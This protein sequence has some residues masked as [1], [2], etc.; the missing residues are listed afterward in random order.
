M[1]V[2]AAFLEDLEIT[3]GRDD[4]R[5]RASAAFLFVR[6]AKALDRPGDPRVLLPHRDHRAVDRAVR[7][8]RA[9][10]RPSCSRRRAALVRHHAPAGRTSSASDPAAPAACWSSGSSPASVATVIG[11]LVGVTAGYL[12]GVGDES[13]VRAVQ[14]VPGDP[15]AAADHHHRRP[16]AVG[17]RAHRRP[18]HRPHRVGVG[19]PRAAGADAVAAATRLRRGGAGQRREHLAD[20]LRG[21]PAEPHRDHRL[22][23]RR[24]GHLRG[25]VPDHAGVHR[26]HAHHR[27]ELGHDPVLGAEPAGPA[28]RRV[29]VVRPGRAAASPC[30]ARR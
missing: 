3:P 21:D 18:G 23:L 8:E 10:R 20:H 25:P 15:A 29:V 7:P 17:R 14:R 5:A 27:V 12:G 22:G 1:T 26:H 16:A 30:S 6:N 2:E 4:A 24:H 9:E 19:C 13:P 11:V 28:A